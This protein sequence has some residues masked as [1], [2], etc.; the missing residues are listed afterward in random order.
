VAEFVYTYN[1]RTF[2]ATYVSAPV[3]A[4]GHWNDNI[5]N[6]RTYQR[7]VQASVPVQPPIFG[8]LALEAV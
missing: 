8:M 4:T 2:S 3:A 7:S 1:G 5:A 6:S